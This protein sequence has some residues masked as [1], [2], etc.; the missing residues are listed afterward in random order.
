MQSE[1]LPVKSMKSFGSVHDP[2]IPDCHVFLFSFSRMFCVSFCYGLQSASKSSN[3]YLE[4]FYD[5]CWEATR[6]KNAAR[7]VAVHLCE[8]VASCDSLGVGK[9]T[10]TRNATL[11]LLFSHDDIS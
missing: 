5:R 10:G 2:I 11:S 7:I 1:R 3:S 8:N 6:F 4:V 9:G